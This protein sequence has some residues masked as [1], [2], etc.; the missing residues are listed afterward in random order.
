MLLLGTPASNC[1]VSQGFGRGYLRRR[2][3]CCT[4]LTV[5][6]SFVGGVSDF[7]EGKDDLLQLGFGSVVVGVGHELNV[8]ARR[9]AEQLPGTSSTT[10]GQMSREGRAILVEQTLFH[11][12]G[13]GV[14]QGVQEV[15]GFLVGD[16]N[17]S[18]GVGSQQAIADEGLDLAGIELLRVLDQGQIDGG[19]RRLERRL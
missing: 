19:G 3:A 11:D 4:D 9:V 14:A 15:A 16:D 17:H 12:V 2:N 7:V 5:L 10:L 1:R 6:V 8:F 13:A 18:L